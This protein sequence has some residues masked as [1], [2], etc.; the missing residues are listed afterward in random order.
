M[1]GGS[2][3]ATL[4]A[5][6]REFQL[7]RLDRSSNHLPLLILELLFFSGGLLVF[8]DLNLAIDD[9]KKQARYAPHIAYTYR[10]SEEK[11]EVPG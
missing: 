3:S 11:R 6:T 8:S 7:D 4:H 1:L 10:E 9:V 5:S 2:S